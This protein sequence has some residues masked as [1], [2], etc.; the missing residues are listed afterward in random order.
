MWWPFLQALRDAL[1][2]WPA[3]AGVTVQVGAHGEVPALDTIE[4]DRGP[5][6]ADDLA[7]PRRGELTVWMDCW[8]QD[9]DDDAA[10][11]RLAAI[12]SAAV[13]ALGNLLRHGERVAGADYRISIQRRES[14]GGIFRP[15][16][17]SRTYVQ[18]EWRLVE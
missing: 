9:T 10:L 14:D 8:T 2:A 3:L 17:G 15:S 16:R 11:A 13:E 6:A 4:L 18:I 5:D 7:N 12:E 1:Q